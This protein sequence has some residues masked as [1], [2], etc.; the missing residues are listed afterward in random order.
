MELFCGFISS[1]PLFLAVEVI[2]LIIEL[3]IQQIQPAQEKVMK[4]TLAI[5]PLSLE[6]FVFGNR[7][8]AGLFVLNFFV[9]AF[10][11]SLQLSVLLLNT[12]LRV[13]LN[14]FKD[15]YKEIKVETQ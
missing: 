2:I 13:H 1:A 3:I 11:K 4:Y 8:P 14:L 10:L 12:F 6:S 5:T 7:S 9:L 15:F